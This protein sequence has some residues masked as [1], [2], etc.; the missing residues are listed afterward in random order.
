VNVLQR[1][2]LQTA[3]IDA[4]ATQVSPPPSK[5][6]RTERDDSPVQAKP[7]GRGS[8]RGGERMP[9]WSAASLLGAMGLEGDAAQLKGEGGADTSAAREA[10]SAMG[11]QAYAKGNQVAF[12][13]SPTLGG[14][15]VQHQLQSS[16][17]DGGGAPAA[18]LAASPTPTGAPLI[19]LL[20]PP[21]PKPS[22][23]PG[24]LDLNDPQV[25]KLL[26]GGGGVVSPG[27]GDPY[28]LDL[29]ISPNPLDPFEQPATNW[30]K[31]ATAV[32]GP[33]TPAEWAGVTHMPKQPLP[34]LR[35]DG[36]PSG[37]VMPDQTEAANQ[38]LA[39]FERVYAAANASWNA[40]IPGITSYSAASKDLSGTGLL[41]TEGGLGWNAGDQNADLSKLTGQQKVGPDGSKTVDDLFKNKDGS[42]GTASNVSAPGVTGTK[43]T[44]ELL[45]SAKRASNEVR[46]SISEH[47]IAQAAT[48]GTAEGVRA[49]VLLVEINEAKIDADKL[50]EEKEQLQK[51][52]ADA[53]EKLDTVV[54]SLEAITL[55]GFGIADAASGGFAH[56]A[57]SIA[58][59]AEIGA[60]VIGKAIIN[61]KYD[62][63]I[64]AAD[65][66]LKTALSGIRSKQG[67]YVQAALNSAVIAHDAA[68]G[69]VRTT[70]ET[71]LAK[72]AA[73][74]SA[75][76][77]F[78]DEAGKAAGGGAKGAQVQ[79]ALEAVPRIEHCL[80][81]IKQIT[82][83]TALPTYSEL[84]GKGFNGFGKPADFV[85]YL[86]QMKGY[87]DKFQGLETMW[88]ARLVS[89]KALEKQLGM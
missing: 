72:V 52:K 64:E 65:K 84:S 61:A 14:G 12:G 18:S 23:L 16:Q 73:Y 39:E 3:D 70:K 30:D 27:G 48:K 20:D 55:I 60:E 88:K 87:R 81:Q 24:G 86:A 35:L 78:A 13:E 38:A 85:T 66:Q 50:K 11:A 34:R 25:K 37:R 42:A 4:N 63:K 58:I 57:E 41:G 67:R 6:T 15:G 2:S 17:T 40:M 21:A 5:L 82:S 45:N 10:T 29:G 74:Q 83:A 62:D 47:K 76:D 53:E 69:R 32:P 68:M 79:A 26:G 54:S 36:K 33:D 49:A 7:A 31:L 77:A 71:M 80:G 51:D 56:G 22:P 59:G 28:Q 75:Y 44:K 43:K 1:S 19:S 9:D 89:L 46:T 8:E